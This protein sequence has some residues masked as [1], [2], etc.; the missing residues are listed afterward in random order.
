VPSLALPVVLSKHSELSPS[1]TLIESATLPLRA[2]SEASVAQQ[3]LHRANKPHYVKTFLACLVNM[4]ASTV[5][6]TLWFQ[7]SKC[8]NNNE[9]LMKAVKTWL[10]SKVADFFGTGIQKLTPRY[11]KCLTFGSDYVKE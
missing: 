11:N 7:N 9:E 2:C 3:F 10:S 6:T 8:F 5:L 1:N 4:C